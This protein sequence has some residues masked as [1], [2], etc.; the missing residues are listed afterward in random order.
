VPALALA[1]G[2]R[3]AAPLGSGFAGACAE[4]LTER[5]GALAYYDDSF[6]RDDF[7]DIILNGS[8]PE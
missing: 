2:V 5:P 4:L 7:V 1:D 8:W 3:V 6:V